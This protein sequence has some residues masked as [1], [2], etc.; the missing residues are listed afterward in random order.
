MSM[1]NASATRVRGLN[2]SL[3][4]DNSI[5]DNNTPTTDLQ[6]KIKIKDWSKTGRG[7]HVEFEKHEKVPLEQGINTSSGLQTRQPTIQVVSLV[8][9]LWEMCTKLKLEA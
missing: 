2:S 1:D 8:E 4:I 7:S 3:V 5:S 6:D 9:V